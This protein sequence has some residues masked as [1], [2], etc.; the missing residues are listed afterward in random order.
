V[1]RFSIIP[2]FQHPKRPLLPPVK[3]GRAIRLNKVRQRGKWVSGL[4]RVD[5]FE[6]REAVE[7]C[8]ACADLPD[9]ML[10]HE[11]GCVRVVKQ[12]AREVRQ[13]YD[14]LPS[15]GR[16]PLSW[17]Q[18]TE[19][20]RGEESLDEGPRFPCVPRPSHDSRMS[21]HAQELIQDR[22]GN[23]PSVRPPSLTFEPV[24]TGSVERRV[25]VGGVNQNI[26]VNDEHYRPSIAWYRASRSATS[27]SVPPLWSVGSGGSSC[28]FF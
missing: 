20:G 2:P 6:K 3:K 12:I 4:D 1:R 16:V 8:I 26:G 24:A 22:P 23:I 13:L 10:T 18:S 15:H 17:D 28:F 14:D 5:N 9:S 11:D 25:A 27:T 7:V 21:C 19:S